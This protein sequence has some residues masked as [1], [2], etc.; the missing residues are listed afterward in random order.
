MARIISKEDNC[1][2]TEESEIRAMFLM[3]ELHY[4]LWLVGIKLL[5]IHVY[6]EYKSSKLTILLCE[7]L[8][9]FCWLV[10]FLCYFYP[11][12][13]FS[14]FPA[15][16][17]VKEFFVGKYVSGSS[18]VIWQNCIWIY[19]EKKFTVYPC[20]AFDL[21]ALWKRGEL[22]R[23]NQEILTNIIKKKYLF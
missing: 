11:N 22:L 12:N 20:H 15:N 9:L 10:G 3:V 2:S 19:C 6:T 21:S 1:W 5:S 16:N 18:E 7:I 17:I 8:L 23:P 13:M 14:H 4:L